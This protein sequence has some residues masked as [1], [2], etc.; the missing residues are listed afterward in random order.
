MD[1][2][3]KAL[4]QQNYDFQK[5]Q[6]VQGKVYS[7]ETE[8]SNKGVYVD[9]GGK[10]LAFL[11]MKEIYLREDLTLEELLPLKEERDFLI[12][13][14]QDADGQ[15]TLSIKELEAKQS[16]DELIEMEQGGKVMQ[17]TVTGVNKG[18]ITIDI[19]GL[20]GFIPRSHVVDRENLQ[21]IVG[22]SL[23]VNFLEID[24]EREKIVMS[25]R[26]ATQAASFSTLSI[27]QLFEGKVTSIKPFG[28]FIEMNGIS[29]LLHI[30]QIS[31]TYI[32]SIPKL[33]SI[34][35]EVK[36]LIIDLDAGKRRITLSTRVLENYPGEMIQ[37]MAEVME[38]AEARAE[39][40]LKNIKAE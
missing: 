16:W 35:Q 39:R 28:V 7:Y 14:D 3:A 8:G 2:F 18:G 36:A 27:G 1:D 12:I 34:G 26:M 29:G 20:R 17:V 15:V 25:E 6:V 24:R 38:S 10:S 21:T 32:D 5:G 13:R 19:H 33:F 31:Q 23:T 9:I 11:P 22:Q 4:E 40:A 37:K 30:K